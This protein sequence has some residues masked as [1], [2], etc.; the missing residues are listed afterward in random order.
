[1]E[2]GT[3]DRLVSIERATAVQDDFGEEILTWAEVFKEWARVFYSRG[4][5]RREAAADRSEMPIT[6][7]VLANSNSRSIVATDRI[8]YD[9]LIWNIEGIAPVTRADIEITAV[10]APTGV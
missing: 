4:N 8:V 1:M 5:E 10:A 9:G 6:F 3:R 7:S 2:A